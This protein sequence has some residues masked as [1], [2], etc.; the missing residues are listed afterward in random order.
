MIRISVSLLLIPVSLCALAMGI[1]MFAAG[2]SIGGINNPGAAILTILGIC[3]IVASLVG[4][5]C[6][7]VNHIS[8]TSRYSDCGV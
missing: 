3:F 7:V 2:L 4:C 6:A 1:A 5:V 8:A